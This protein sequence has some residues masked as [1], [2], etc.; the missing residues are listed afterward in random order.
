MVL[1]FLLVL[2]VFCGWIVFF[3]GA[4]HVQGA[5]SAIDL[6]E[7]PE[8]NDDDRLL[9]LNQVRLWAVCVWML[10]VGLAIYRAA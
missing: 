10:V 3:D 8:P 7:V 4:R 5:V 1:L 9:T 2:T 6:R